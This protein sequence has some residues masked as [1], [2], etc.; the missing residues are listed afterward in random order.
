MKKGSGTDD[1][2]R[3]MAEALR[4]YQMQDCS[5][6]NVTI[7]FHETFALSATKKDETLPDTVEAEARC[8]KGV[9]VHIS[10]KGMCWEGLTILNVLEMK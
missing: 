2:S 6:H 10:K 1:K 9:H 4:E 3:V 5:R 8:T 7:N